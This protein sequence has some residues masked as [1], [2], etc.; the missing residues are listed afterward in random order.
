MV[1]DVDRFVNF[2][3]SV[4]LFQQLKVWQLR[5]LHSNVNCKSYQDNDII[6]YEDSEDESCFYLIFSGRV[7]VMS[8]GSEGEEQIYTVLERGEF[9][10]EMSLLEN[11]PR[12]ASVVAMGSCS[13]YIFTKKQFFRMF[14]DYPVVAIEFMRNL[15]A[16][17]RRSNRRINNFA[18]MSARERLITYLIDS[19]DV[20]GLPQGNG[21]VLLDNMPNQKEI[22]AIIG[23]S[24]ETVSRLMNEFESKNILKKIGRKK[25]LVLNEKLLQV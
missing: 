3:C 16:R 8:I 18:F 11:K 7:K 9:F 15:C 6:V 20:K 24:R 13:L 17:I 4:P 21:T 2:A 14:N 19:V 22:G 1:T 25:V 23:N 12:S 5:L 10:G